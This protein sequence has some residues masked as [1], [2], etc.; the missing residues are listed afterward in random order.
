MDIHF[1]RDLLMTAAIFG[2]F[3]VVWFGWAQERPPAGA[4]I[5]LGIGSGIGLLLAIVFGLLS[6]RNWDA[7]TALGTTDGSWRSYLIIVGVEFTL[8]AAGGIAL[9]LSRWAPFVPLWVLLIVGVH[10]FALAPIFGMPALSI[11]AALLMAAAVAAMIIAIRSDLQ[12]S[13]LAGIFA[14]PLLLAFAI[15]AAALWLTTLGSAKAA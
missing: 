13:F 11:L 14:G 4:A 5:L 1:T 7:P 12:P 6:W 9:A 15:I 10:F 2:F 8:A 3:S